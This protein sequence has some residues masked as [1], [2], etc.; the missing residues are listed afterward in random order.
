[1]LIDESYPKIDFIQWTIDNVA[2]MLIGLRAFSR[3]RITVS[4]I[5]YTVNNPVLDYNLL[6]LFIGKICNFFTIII[7]LN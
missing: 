6:L 2:V 4:V 3:L 1:M 5:L 7:Y